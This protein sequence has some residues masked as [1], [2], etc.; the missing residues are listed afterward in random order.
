MRVRLESTDRVVEVILDGGR[1]P[2]RVWQGQ[3]ESGIEVVAV[4]TS[5]ASRLEADQSKF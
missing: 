5:I 1:V 4:V 3:T 2:G